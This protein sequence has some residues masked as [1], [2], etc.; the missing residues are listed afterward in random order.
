[1]TV[2]KEYFSNQKISSIFV[3]TKLVSYAGKIKR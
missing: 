3:E 2:M 1:M